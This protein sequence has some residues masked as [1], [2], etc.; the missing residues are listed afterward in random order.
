MEINSSWKYRSCDLTSHRPF[1]AFGTMRIFST[2]PILILALA[3]SLC[4]APLSID[5]FDA[6]DSR[7]YFC[8]H[9]YKGIFTRYV[10]RGRRWNF[11]EAAIKKAVK[12][13]PG[14]VMDVWRYRDW[15]EDGL[16]SFDVTVGSR[17]S[18]DD[19]AFIADPSRVVHSS[20]CLF[21]A[22]TGWKA[23]ST[24]W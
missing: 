1:L 19:L 7:E 18:P 17:I 10:L 14:C 22:P 12:K 5:D 16:N 8:G 11:D 13:T 20:S 24:S 15:E 21:C 2:I 6:L 4:A 9:V 23:N 3:S